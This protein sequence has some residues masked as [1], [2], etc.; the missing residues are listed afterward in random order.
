MFTAT[1]GSSFKENSPSHNLIDCLNILKLF[2][3]ES[4]VI[5]RPIL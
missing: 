1:E 2:Q 5:I 4:Y 3:V